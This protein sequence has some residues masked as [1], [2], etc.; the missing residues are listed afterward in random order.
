M[1]NYLKIYFSAKLER[2]EYVY[3]SLPQQAQDER[4]MA[5]INSRTTEQNNGIEMAHYKTSSLK[6]LTFKSLKSNVPSYNF[7][8]V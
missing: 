7:M 8:I 5:L 6:Y 4:N 3:T 1:G 2:D